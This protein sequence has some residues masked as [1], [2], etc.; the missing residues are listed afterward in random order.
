M[1]LEIDANFA[2]G[3]HERPL[4]AMLN[5]VPVIA[6]DNK[7]YHDHFEVGKEIMLYS[8]ND[9]YDLSEKLSALLKASDKLQD[10]SEAGYSAVIK[11]HTYLQMTEQI[12]SLVDTYKAFA[13]LK[14]QMTS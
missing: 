13:T 4:T 1:C 12:L 2:Y 11:K 8:P 5:H 10:I 6:S 9:R 3:S 7:Y 14:I